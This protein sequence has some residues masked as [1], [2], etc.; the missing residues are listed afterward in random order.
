MYNESNPETNPTASS[1]IAAE[2]TSEGTPQDLYFRIILI[3]VCVSIVMVTVG[4]IWLI[5]KSKMCQIFEYQGRLGSPSKMKHQSTHLEDINSRVSQTDENITYG[6]LSSYETTMVHTD[7]AKISTPS[8]AVTH[9]PVKLALTQ[10]EI[11]QVE[12]EGS[13][14]PLRILE[15]KSSNGVRMGD[16]W[17]QDN[18]RRDSL[19]D[20]TYYYPNL[21]LQ[22]Q[23]DNEN[24]LH[25]QAA[26]DHTACLANMKRERNSLYRQTSDDFIKNCLP[27]R[28]G[29]NGTFSFQEISKD[30]SES[31]RQSNDNYI[32]KDALYA[33]RAASNYDPSYHY[34]SMYADQTSQDNEHPQYRGVNDVLDTG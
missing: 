26:E 9:L 3:G 12:Q 27:F 28:T 16:S 34:P 22:N 17:T 19:D 1:L 11:V 31:L 14:L 32:Y 8:Y 33:V 23:M 10:D 21:N 15:S 2:T 6:L 18:T 20:H 5:I 4:I 7:P 25:P 30:C 29:D 13:T 24:F